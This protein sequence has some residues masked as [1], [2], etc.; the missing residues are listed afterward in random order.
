M[1]ISPLGAELFQADERRD[2]TNVKVA[3]AILWTRKGDNKI[4]VGKPEGKKII[5]FKCEDF[6]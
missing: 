6:Y 4:V 1:K 3:F 5:R 2:L